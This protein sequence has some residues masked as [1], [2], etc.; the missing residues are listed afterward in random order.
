MERALALARRARGRTSPN[1]AV[2]AVVVRDG[3]VVGEGFTQPPGQA[4]AE[5]VALCQAGLL[6]PGATLYVTLEPCCFHGRTPPCT[7]AI[8]A[9][10]IAEVHLATLDPNPRVAGRGQAE[11][12]RAGI[13]TVL[14]NCAEAARE[15]IEGFSQLI[16][17]GRPWVTAKFA[18]S[19][20][21]KI[22]TRTGD[23][24]WITGPAARRRVHELRDDL[25]AVLVGVETA[26]ADDPQLTVRLDGTARDDRQPLRVVADSRGRLPL[27]ARM[28]GEPGRTLV[29][30]TAVSSDIWRQALAA[31]GVEVVV[32]PADAAGRVDLPALL[33]ALGAR[34]I[35]DLLVEGGG[36][37]LGALFEAQLVDKVYAFVAPVIIGGEGAPSPVR[38]I[39][40]DRLADA[41]QLRRVRV[42]QVGP[43]L[44]IL[45]YV[46]DHEPVVR[47]SWGNTP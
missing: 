20:D 7:A 1:P 14:G 41:W 40:A 28:L 27:G 44:L 17:S 30:T 36:R 3:A 6:A 29:A 2:G 38:G 12:E 46:N 24:R 9:A 39:G 13:A 8:I 23:T 42:E 47:W 18:M 10:G 19:L 35:A 25:D 45:G 15:Q 21:G 31:R 16:T 22:A 5:V 33:Q 11:L 32:L 43:D 37:L 26:L 4:H 34:G